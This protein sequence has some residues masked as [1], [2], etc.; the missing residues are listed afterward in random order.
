MS[1]GNLG[2]KI[3]MIAENGRREA[4]SAVAQAEF[5]AALGVWRP[6]SPKAKLRQAYS[7]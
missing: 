6:W 5:L 2:I 1:F 7:A 4:R 3:D